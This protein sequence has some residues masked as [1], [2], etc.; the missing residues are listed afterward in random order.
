M[1][2]TDRSI[3]QNFRWAVF[4]S[5]DIL[6]GHFNIQINMLKWCFGRFWTLRS[7]REPHSESRKCKVKL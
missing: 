2:N 1:G 5:S 6:A 7:E 3:F 4:Q